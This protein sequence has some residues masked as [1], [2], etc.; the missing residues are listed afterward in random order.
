MMLHWATTCGLTIS[1][2]DMANAQRYTSN[3][4]PLY[5]ANNHFKDEMWRIPT[6]IVEGRRKSIRS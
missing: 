2:M 1:I 3:Y 5:F 6:A 4:T